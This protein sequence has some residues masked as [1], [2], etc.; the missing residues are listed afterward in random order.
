[1]CCIVLHGLHS[2]RTVDKIKTA[3]RIR[4]QMQSPFSGNWNQVRIYLL[5]C[6]R[7]HV[8]F[9]SSDAR[10]AE[11]AGDGDRCATAEPA[12]HAQPARYPHG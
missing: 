12:Q 3:V 9:G 4:L 5:I 10:L 6:L 7:A 11:C 1:M 8:M 2:M